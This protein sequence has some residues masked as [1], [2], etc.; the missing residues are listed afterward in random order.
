MSATDASRACRISSASIRGRPERTGTSGCQ[1]SEAPGT[2]RRSGWSRSFRGRLRPFLGT[3]TRLQVAGLGY[4]Q[5]PERPGRLHGDRL[6]GQADVVA[7]L[8][9]QRYAAYRQPVGALPEHRRAAGPGIHREAGELVDGIPRLGA[10][11]LGEWQIVSGQEVNDQVAGVQRHPVGVVGLG[12]P[13][14]VPLRLNAGPAYVFNGAPILP[15]LMPGG[16]SLTLDAC[17]SAPA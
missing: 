1:V 3:V 12:Q 10:E 14:A 13:H 17:V 4:P 15:S 11:Q 2:C 8:V 6:G 5:R 7:A 9:K 16:S